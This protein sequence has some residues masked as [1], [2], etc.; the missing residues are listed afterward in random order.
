MKE[1]LGQI[2]DKIRT[3]EYL[4][5]RHNQLT[6]KEVGLLSNCT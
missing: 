5:I 1:S 3:I 6:E 2:I 4:N